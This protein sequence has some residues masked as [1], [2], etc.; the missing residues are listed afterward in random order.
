[1]TVLYLPVGVYLVSDYLADVYL[2]EDVY[3]HAGR[4]VCQHLAVISII[5]FYGTFYYDFG[6]LNLNLVINQE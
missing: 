4:A 2:P 5:L 3:I 6:E 1:M